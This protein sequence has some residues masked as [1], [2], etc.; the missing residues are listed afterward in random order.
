MS[1]RLDFFGLAAENGGQRSIVILLR[2]VLKMMQEIFGKLSMRELRLASDCGGI[3]TC[4]GSRG[5][6]ATS[7]HLISPKL[8][9]VRL[10]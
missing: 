6:Q 3:Y 1:M 5:L 7:F 10:L 9:Q 2:L 8:G 4:C